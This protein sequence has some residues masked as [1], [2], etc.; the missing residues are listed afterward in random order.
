MYNSTPKFLIDTTLLIFPNKYLI[1]LNIR[2]SLYFFYFFETKTICKQRIH[3]KTSLKKAKQ[4]YILRCEHFF[5]L[6]LRSKL[7]LRHKY[8]FIKSLCY[9]TSHKKNLLKF[10]KSYYIKKK[11]LQSMFLYLFLK[12]IYFNYTFFKLKIAVRKKMLYTFFILIENWHYK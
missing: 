2:I 5:K 6:N 4:Q 3:K 10:L 8:F 11:F 1:F 9:S 12:S 7:Y